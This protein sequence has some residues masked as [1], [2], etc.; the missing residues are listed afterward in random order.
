MIVDDMEILRRDVKRLKLWGEDSGFIITEEAKNGWEALDKLES[1]SF[2]LVITDI[3]MPSMDGMELLRNIFEKNLCPFT[4]LL[5]DYAEYRYAKQGFLYGAFDY[6][7]KPVEEQELKNLLVRIKKQLN[8]KIK[9]ESEL[10]TLQG[11]ANDVMY[12]EE[13]T[14][15]VVLLFQKGD[16]K[17]VAF[18]SD[19]LDKIGIYFNTDRQKTLLLLHKVMHEIIE[20]T[21]KTH[22][23]IGL[24]LDMDSL[25]IINFSNCSNWEGVKGQAVEV[26]EK[27]ITNISRFVGDQNNRIVKQASDYILR[28]IDK[29]LSVKTL[30]EKLFVNRAYLSEIFKQQCGMTVLEYITMVKMERAKKLLADGELKNYEIAEMLGFR[31]NEYFARL[32]KKHTGVLPK[33]FI[34]L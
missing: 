32:F 21:M 30:S 7:A 2:D 34:N 12:T 23:W 11:I 14:K 31:D 29:E 24:F 13:D 3:K 18:A 6:I 9:Q 27:L 28:H 15:Q 22:D 8:D 5:S 33:D 26:F 4:V 10:R 25:R 16:P 19:L 17:A 20:H 1:G